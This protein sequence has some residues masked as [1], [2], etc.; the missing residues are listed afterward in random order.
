MKFLLEIATP[1]GKYLTTEIEFLELSTSKGMLGILP[2]H[3]PLIGDVVLGVVMTRNESIDTYYATSGGLIKIENNKVSLLLNSIE[4]VDDIDSGRAEAAKK[5]ALERLEEAKYNDK[6]D[7]ARAQA[8][9]SRA[10]NRL[11]LCSKISSK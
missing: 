10:I 7:V 2:N 4:L 5:R 8:S 3:A 11:K 1:F 6:I 9:L